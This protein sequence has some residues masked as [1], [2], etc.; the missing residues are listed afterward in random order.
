MLL[1]IKIQAKIKNVAKNYMF[2]IST[3]YD[4]AKVWVVLEWLMTCEI[5]S[6]ASVLR[7]KSDF[8]KKIPQTIALLRPIGHNSGDA[9]S[10]VTSSSVLLRY[11]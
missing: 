9:Y 11:N 2:F 10:F 5:S 8:S 4:V 1:G 7:K 6:N 3:L